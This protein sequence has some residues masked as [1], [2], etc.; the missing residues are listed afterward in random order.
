MRI[1]GIVVRG[2]QLGRT[3][4]FPTANLQ[5]ERIEGDGPGG[6]YAAWFELDGARLPC[7]LNVGSHPTLPGGGQRF[8]AHIFRF[9]GDLYGKR[10][11]VETVEYLRSETR[12]SSPEALARQLEYDRE[13][14]L[15]LLNIQ[16]DPRIK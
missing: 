6:V 3:L 7:M 11:A 16:T 14:S 10:A 1:E 2:R 8:E 5:P 9:D 15:E 12:F 13:R 4:G